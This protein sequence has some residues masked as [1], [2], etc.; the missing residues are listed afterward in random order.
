[1][2]IGT[3]TK[4]AVRIDTPDPEKPVNQTLN[5]VKNG[6]SEAQI[7]AVGEALTQFSATAALSSVVETIQN[8]YVK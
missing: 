3:T 8:E 7:V 6:A 4:L 5:R 2:K 1:M